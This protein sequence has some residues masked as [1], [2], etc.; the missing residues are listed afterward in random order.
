M[1]DEGHD[2]TEKILKEIEKRI[3]AEYAQAE[4]EIAEKLDDYLR[5]FEVKDKLKQKALANGLITEEEYKQWRIGQ[6]MMGQRWA[7][8]RDS[9]AQDF[10]NADQIARSIAFDHM[11]EV[12]AI[13]H[14]YGTFQVEKGS[15]MDT[16]YTLYDRHA[17]EQLVKNEDTFIPAPGRKVSRDIK[18][19]KALAW[20]KKQVQSVMMQ[21]LIQGESIPKLATR[22]ADT[23]GESDRKAAIRNARTMTT[24]VQ[25]AGRMASYDRANKMGIETR[26][27]WLATLDTRTRHWHASLDGAVVDND[28]PFVNEF[29]EIMYP[30]D[31]AAAPSNIFNCRCTLIASI[32][33]FERDLS[34]MNLRRDE[35]LGDM[36]Y[37]EWREGHYKQTS[38]PITKQDSIA[39]TMKQSY[40]NDYRAI[41]GQ[42][43]IWSSEVTATEVEPLLEKVI[44]ESK[45]NV[46]NNREEAYNS[47]TTLFENVADTNAI[48]E[49]LLIDN[50]KRLNELN[51]RFKILNSGNIG[52]CTFDSQGNVKAWVVAPHNNTDNYS[53]NLSP[54]YFAN[55]RVLE[56]IF[57]KE[58]TSGFKMPALDEYSRTYTIIHE[59]G[60]MLAEFIAK[61]RQK[62]GGRLG[63][64]YVDE[65]Q[66]EYKKQ[67]RK[68]LKEIVNIA[69]KNNPGFSLGNNLSRYG[70]DNNDDMFAE[71]FANSQCGAPN[72]LGKA[73]NEWLKKE[74]F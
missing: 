70:F 74:G 9:I 11:P 7:E 3:S 14:D 30:G 67:L 34:D 62:W 56:M 53:L 57:F 48:D 15:L 6:V 50:V 16:S 69:E 45:I 64:D 49:G 24:G 28:E 12:Y 27:Q 66:K 35:K 33:G 59:Y 20:N 44:G 26:K 10:T 68:M 55:P 60:H 21:G 4:K 39:H 38:D 61:R 40:V 73:M 32:K 43:P 23:V 37:E 72:E 63:E 52:Y 5:K 54:T 36:S 25:N 18:E 2:E 51:D 29:G 13:N 71:I 22:L 1:R 8:M 41:A 58:R 17:F 31:P 46:V 47:L 19:G 65:P 42:N